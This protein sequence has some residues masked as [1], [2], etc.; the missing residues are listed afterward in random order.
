MKGTKTLGRGDWTSLTLS[1]WLDT[2]PSDVLDQTL[3][4]WRNWSYGDVLRTTPSDW[5]A[6][7]YGPWMSR[8]TPATA[9]PAHRRPH[10]RCAD[11]RGDHDDLP[12][13]HRH[14]GGCCDCDQ[15]RC[16]CLCCVGD[17]DLALYARVGE[18]R[19]V[20]I[21]VANERRRERTMSLE[22]S[23]WA[24]HGG[25]PA[26]VH[27]VALEPREFTLAPCA[28]Q[29]VKLTVR[30]RGEG[31]ADDEPGKDTREALADVDR[32][33]VV[34]ADLR[35]VGCDHRPVRIAVAILPR[36]CDGFRI[37]CGCACC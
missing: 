32:C 33:E 28:E 3:P 18:E 31:R 4:G 22:L 30:V 24:T 14:D 16:E 15:E 6:M 10:R 9:H 5:L 17:V 35:L 34:T 26:P 29:H 37:S 23:S 20:P 11:C 21:T 8:A 36:T 2:A 27:T 12:G 19:V 25:R 13:W 7:M 1:N